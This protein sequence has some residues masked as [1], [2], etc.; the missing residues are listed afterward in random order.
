MGRDDWLRIDRLIAATEYLVEADSF[1][2]LALWGQNHK[3]LRWES[4]SIGVA[5]HLGTLDDMPVVVHLCWGILAG[6]T[7][8]FWELVSMV[9]DLRMWYRDR[10]TTFPGIRTCDAMNF[11]NCLLDLGIK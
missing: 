1:A 2:R 4:P 3:S 10:A 7:V 8:C 11:H 5:R 9:T 6:H